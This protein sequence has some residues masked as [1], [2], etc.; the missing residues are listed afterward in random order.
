MGKLAI[1]ELKRLLTCIRP[2][3]RVI[4]PPQMG[5][6]A[7]VHQLGDKYVVVAT[8]PC[9][10]VPEEWFGFLLIN[11]AA[12]D[13]TLFGA[14]PEFCTITLMG[15]L[16]TKPDKFQ[17]AMAQVCSAANELGIAIVRGHTG[18][19]GG[20]EELTG[21]CTVYGTALPENLLTPAKVEAEDLILCT[22]PIGLETVVNFC[23]THKARAQKLFGEE[24]AEELSGR[25]P[26]QSCVREALQLAEYGGVHAMHDAT[27]GGFVSA[28]NELS[29]VTKLG[30]RVDCDQLPIV[31][32]ARILQIE[33]GLSDEQVLSMSSTGTILAAVD[34]EVKEKVED[35]LENIGLHAS[36]VG[37]FIQNRNCTVVQNKKEMLFPRV[38]QDPYS[39]I[40]MAK[41]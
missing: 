13:V 35:T 1:N 6:D 39:Q 36:F 28:L 3:L 38:A 14:R 5:F 41:T 30:F 15:P 4:V 31:P 40:M 10:G 18:T 37:K 8:D 19:Y 26:M 11:Y 33:F 7:G 34:A 22:K 2:D 16:S 12:S 23:L 27:E 9:V 20:I 29:E 25:V 32:E 21:V 24:R 17:A